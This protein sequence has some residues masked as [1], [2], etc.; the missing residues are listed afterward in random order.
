MRVDTRNID[1]APSYISIEARAR[2][3][4]THLWVRIPSGTALE[5][6]RDE[7]R[8][9]AAEI[10]RWLGEAAPA[11]QQAREAGRSAFG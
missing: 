1:G 11:P 6:S 2:K 7:A 4:H 5:V 10:L 9:I 3:E 8:S